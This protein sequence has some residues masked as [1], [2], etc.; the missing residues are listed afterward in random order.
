MSMRTTATSFLHASLRL[1]HREKVNFDAVDEEVRWCQNPNTAEEEVKDH[2][3]WWRRSR[4]LRASVCWQSPPPP[5]SA[6]SEGWTLMNSFPLIDHARESDRERDW[7]WRGESK[8]GENENEGQY[9]GGVK[10]EERGVRD[11]RA[12]FV[13]SVRGRRAEILAARVVELGWFEFCLALSWPSIVASDGW[14]ECECREANRTER[15][16]CNSIRH[17]V[18]PGPSHGKP[19]RYTRSNQI[20]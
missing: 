14:S 8:I 4:P 9:K 18:V 1:N 10:R 17:P 5:S 6:V 12:D 3:I 20:P 11:S 15:A 19:I 13:S 2:T 7:K 16:R